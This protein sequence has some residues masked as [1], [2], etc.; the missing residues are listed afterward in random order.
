MVSHDSD[1][2]LSRTLFHRRY[3]TLFDAALG[4]IL[5]IATPVRG[6][7]AVRQCA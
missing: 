6:C 3:L 1:K 7:G 2:V 5:R 4:A